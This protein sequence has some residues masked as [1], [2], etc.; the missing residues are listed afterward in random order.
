MRAVAGHRRRGWTY[1]S[2]AA[3]FLKAPVARSPAGSRR[4][5]TDRRTAAAAFPNMRSSKPVL[6]GEMHLRERAAN[7]GRFLLARHGHPGFSPG[8]RGLVE[9][10]SA[11][12]A[13]ACGKRGRFVLTPD[14]QMEKSH[15]TRYAG[16]RLD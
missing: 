11:C 7:F 6:P 2:S 14:G 4:Q 8:G 3:A 13:R 12:K 16:R 9:K 15:P 5:A 10:T 1:G